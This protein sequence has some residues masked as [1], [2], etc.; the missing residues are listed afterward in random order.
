MEPVIIS[1]RPWRD[2][3]GSVLLEFLFSALLL[4]FIFAGIVNMG[5]IYKDRLVLAGAVREAGR[6]AAVFHNLTEAEQRG[7]TFLKAHG[8]TGSVRLNVVRGG[9]YVEVE[10]VVKTPVMIPGMNALMGG[11]SWDSAIEIRDTKLFRA[12]PA[13]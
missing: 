5:L 3:R 13:P 4:V 8:L 9:R 11:S 2:Q 10:G 6:T 7:Q 1:G 12:E